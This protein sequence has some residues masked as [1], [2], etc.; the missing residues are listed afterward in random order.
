M[1]HKI[2]VVEDDIAIQGFCQTV[3]ESAGFIVTAVA[4]AAEGL[5]CFQQETP[6]MVILD[7]GLPDGNGLDL[8]K[9]MGLGPESAVSFLFLTARQD[10]NTRLECFQSGAQDYIQKPF[11]VEE[12]LAR[13]KVHLKI[14]KSHDELVK[15]NYELELRQRA[16]QDL[17][18]MLVHDLK[19]PLTS[20]KG[21]LELIKARGL[22]SDEAYKNLLEYAGTAAEFMLLM[23]N[24]LLDLGQA[25]TVGLKAEIAPADV[26]FIFDKLV[27]LFDGRT[28][29][30][31]VG[32][33]CTVGPD[34]KSIDLDQNLVFR[35]LANL[36]Q[37]AL[38][39]SDKGGKVEVA[40]MRKDGMARFT[41]ADRGPGVPK[42]D[43]ERIF[44]KYTTTS[45]KIVATD[46]GS[47]VGLTFCRMASGALK[48][49]VWVEDRPG[50]GS[51][52]ILEFPAAASKT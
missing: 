33:E 47:G 49:K 31:G 24:D 8:G 6:D 22:I 32:L 50:G 19:A 18:D 15:R 39:A 2:L 28:R 46:S 5:Q 51:L 44:E 27:A 17:T 43:K 7:I 13:V 26:G 25:A 20:I 36:I 16:R 41:V 23:L 10:L 9:K 4:T 29:K 45:R 42:A 48:G 30:L 37:N 11:A 14:K 40:S 38:K 21:T 3:L 52:F 34:A 35:I 12:L 1:S